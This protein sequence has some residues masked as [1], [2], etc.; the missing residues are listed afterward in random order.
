MYNADTLHICV[1]AG[2]DFSFSMCAEPSTICVFLVEVIMCA[3]NEPWQ[4][5]DNT[6]KQ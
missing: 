6:Q 1:N 2:S 4:L 5:C 3:V